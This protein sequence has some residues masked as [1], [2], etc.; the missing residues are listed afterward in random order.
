VQASSKALLCSFNNKLNGVA[1][2]KLHLKETACGQNT[3][4]LACE[5]LNADLGTP[6]GAG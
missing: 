2:F 6:T 5:A 3:V 4:D 1:I